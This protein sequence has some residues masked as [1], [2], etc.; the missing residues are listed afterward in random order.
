MKRELKSLADVADLDQG[1]VGEQF[2]VDLAAV[3]ADVCDR[4]ALKRARKITV[5]LEI[6]PVA[7]ADGTLRDLN[8]AVSL[9][10][11][12]PVSRSQT[13]SMKWAAKKSALVYN[14]EA[15]ENADQRTLDEEAGRK[16][17]K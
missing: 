6:E 4:P 17:K 10:T 15:P 3:M 11:T 16:E 12:A 2:K 7:G 13:V 8:V 5:E 9:K 1:A 14:D